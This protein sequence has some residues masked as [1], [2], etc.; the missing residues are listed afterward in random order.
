M[1]EAIASTN[2]A[3]VCRRSTTKGG[4]GG[5]PLSDDVVLCRTDYQ[6]PLLQPF[7]ALVQVRL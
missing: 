5:P 4:P 7:V 6:L 1:R 3:G 2:V